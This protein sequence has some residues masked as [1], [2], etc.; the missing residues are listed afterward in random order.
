MFSLFTKG[1]S[2][3]WAFR[4]SH[5]PLRQMTAST[6]ING[7]HLPKAAERATKYG[8]KDV[9]AIFTPLANAHKAVNLGQG[10]P[11]IPAPAFVKVIISAR[12]LI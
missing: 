1:L 7:Y 2:G 9:W 6:Q 4:L 11:N 5:H 10:F 3:G 8:E 12:A